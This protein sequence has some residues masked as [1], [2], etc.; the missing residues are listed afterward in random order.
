LIGA[1]IYDFSLTNYVVSPEDRSAMTWVASNTP[2]QSRFV[3]ITG[4][5][6][7]LND[8]VVEWFP[9]YSL[10][11]SQSTVQGREWLLGKG[12]LPFLGSLDGL[13]SCLNSAPSCV[14]NW[15]SSDHLAFDYLYIQKP[16]KNNPTSG[17]LL[18]LLRGSPD[19]TLVFENNSAAIF[20]RK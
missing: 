4:R 12:F 17:L 8:P 18:Y 20:A 16:T 10:R 5:P 7:P 19:Y 11:T 9:V 1:L 3:V 2:T 15:A 13:Q 6:D 14:E